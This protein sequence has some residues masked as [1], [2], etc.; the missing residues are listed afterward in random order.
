MELWL[1]SNG[2]ILF[3]VSTGYA[4]VFSSQPV[5]LYINK[6]LKIKEIDIISFAH[7]TSK[8]YPQ[9]FIA[10]YYTKDI[11]YWHELRRLVKIVCV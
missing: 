11:K 3:K 4:R 2:E 8:E 1:Q 7:A 5:Y 10:M 9:N 6:R